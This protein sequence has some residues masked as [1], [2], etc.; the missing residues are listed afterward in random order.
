MVS[1]TSLP[2]VLRLAQGLRWRVG[3]PIIGRSAFAGFGAEL[4]PTGFLY[5]STDEAFIR[6]CSPVSIGRYRPHRSRTSSGLKLFAVRAAPFGERMPSTGSS[7]SLPRRPKKLMDALTVTVGGGNAD[8]G[9]GTGRYGGGNDRGFNYRIYGISFT[10]ESGVSFVGTPAAILTTGEMGQVGVPSGL[11]SRMLDDTLSRFK[12]MC[13]VRF[14]RESNHVCTVF[15]SLP[16]S[17]TSMRMPELTGGNLLG[18]WKH[19]LNERLGL[20][21]AGLL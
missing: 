11:G 12:V 10:R 1:A 14:P 21:G 2:E 20:P 18:R 4:R 9:A 7:T 19:V 3:L 6:R 16:P 15:A 5:S 8:Q 17:C 13:T